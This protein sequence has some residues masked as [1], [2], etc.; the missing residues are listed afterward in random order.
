MP[1]G[2]KTSVGNKGGVVGDETR[3]EIDESW[4]DIDETRGAF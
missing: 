3:D 4:D 2:E 1:V